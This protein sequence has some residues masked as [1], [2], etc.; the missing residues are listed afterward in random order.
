MQMK[1]IV[2]GQENQRTFNSVQNGQNVTVD[3]VD[4][5]L[6]DGLNN[7]VATAFEKEAIRLKEN[8]LAKGSW[9]MVDLAFNVR[10]SKTD[11][12]EYSYQQVRLN[13]YVALQ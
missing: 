2:C 5:L 8:P 9:V 11:K 1:L 12:G 13:K 6:T 3:A 4:V 10:T 7:F